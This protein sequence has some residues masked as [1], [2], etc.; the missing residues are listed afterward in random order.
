V[1]GFVRNDR[2]SAVAAAVA[3][4]LNDELTVILSS[5]TGSLIVLDASHP[6]HEML[7][8]LQ[9]AAQRCA[10]R[11]ARLLTFSK[12]RGLR[13]FPLTVERLLEEEGLR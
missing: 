3:Q 9:S 7:L 12:R 5:V 13:Q 1:Q 11:A 4:D 10:W 8:E 2:A 6:A